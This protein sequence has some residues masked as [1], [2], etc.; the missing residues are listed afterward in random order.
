VSLIKGLLARHWQSLGEAKELYLLLLDL[1][2]R[3]WSQ[4]GTQSAE[5]RALGRCWDLSGAETQL[6]SETIGR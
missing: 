4:T 2:E 1:K 3:K 5:E 6:S